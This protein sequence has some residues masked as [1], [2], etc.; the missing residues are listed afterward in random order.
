MILEIEGHPIPWKSHAGYGRRSFNPLYKERAY[1]Q[2]QLKNQ[3]GSGFNLISGPV[4]V[5]FSYHFPFPKSM[6]KK[7]RDSN[8][9]HVT[10]PDVTNCQKFLEDCLKGII[11][12]DDSQ[13]VE[14]T[15]RKFYSEHAKTVIKI[16]ELCMLKI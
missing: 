8:P 15:G 1:V 9:F 14:V 2:W 10:K 5:V 6:S 4:S 13:V 7:K 11:I 3:I 12:V 16:E